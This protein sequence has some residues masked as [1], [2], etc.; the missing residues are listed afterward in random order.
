MLRTKKVL[1]GLKWAAR[2]YQWIFPYHQSLNKNNFETA[3]NAQEQQ[4]TLR[5]TRSAEDN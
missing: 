3:E 1:S 5:K 2:R 4:I